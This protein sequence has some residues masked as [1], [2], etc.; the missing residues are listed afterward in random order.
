[1]QHLKVLQ[2]ILKGSNN[3]KW[4]YG[5]TCS[6]QQWHQNDVYIVVSFLLTLNSMWRFARFGSI[7]TVL[8]MWK[9]WR[10][11][12]FSKVTGFSLQLYKVTLLHRQFSCFLNCTDGTKSLTVIFFFFLIGSEIGFEP[13]P[14]YFAVLKEMLRI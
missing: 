6:D 1:M 12:T 7:S 10:N 9:S 5:V 2:C 13:L 8:K 14:R 11:F 3:K 4:S